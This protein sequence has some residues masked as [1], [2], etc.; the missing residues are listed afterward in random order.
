MCRSSRDDARRLAAQTKPQ[1]RLSI[2]SQILH[3]PLITQSSKL[4]RCFS[5]KGYLFIMIN[6]ERPIIL[7]KANSDRKKCFKAARTHQC[8]VIFCVFASMN[9]DDWSSVLRLRDVTTHNFLSKCGW[10]TTH[11]FILTVKTAVNVLRSFPSAHI[12]CYSAERKDVILQ[13]PKL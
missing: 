6:S 7:I 2:Y 13:Y 3:T 10:F 9:S 1:V 11:L 12:C 8:S 5:I 4:I